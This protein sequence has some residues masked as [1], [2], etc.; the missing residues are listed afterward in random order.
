MITDVLQGRRDW[1]IECGDALAVLKSMPSGCVQCCVTSPPYW[2]QRDYGDKAQLGLEDTPDEYTV[3]LVKILREVRRVLVDTAT[4][5]LN[6]GDK[7][8]SG[9]NGGGGSFMKER[10]G[11]TWAHAKV[12]K[13]WRK[14]PAGFKD[15]DLVGLPWMVAFALRADGWWLRSEVIW[16]KLNGA[17]ES[18]QD[19]PT[20][21]HETVFLLAK[22]K[23][24][25]FDMEAVRTPAV[26]KAQ[27]RLRP[28]SFRHAP[29][30]PKQNGQIPVREEIAQD[31]NSAAM[32]SVLAI[33][34]EGG[35]RDYD[36]PAPMPTQLGEVCVLA[37]CPLDGIV[38]DPFAGSGTSLIAA[39]RNGR[40]AIGV[41]LNP[42]Y[43]A[44]SRKRIESDSPLFNTQPVVSGETP[45]LFTE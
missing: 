4:L 2:R 45:L 42:A 35:N 31:Y 12:S 16:A 3:R 44:T 37:G 40:R 29:G 15:K 10:G 27:R 20:R 5:W 9:G 38:I 6:M 28:H 30:Q 36:H 8:A 19:R 32:R 39:T 18:V 21:A 17:T 25:H 23:N 7:Y 11:R 13:G 43:A 14:P 41:E 34:T 22:S 26:M 1:W 24:Y 33:P